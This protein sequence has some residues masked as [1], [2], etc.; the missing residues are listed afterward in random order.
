M[1]KKSG[2][3]RE[4]N[5]RVKIAFL[6]THFPSLSETFILNQVTGLLDRG[7]E[8]HVYAQRPGEMSVTHPDVTRY[9]L[10]ERTR[11]APER[12]GN[13]LHR[14]VR[15]L[16]L[17]LEIG[18]RAPGILLRSLNVLRQGRQAT[19]LKLLFSA[20]PFLRQATRYDILHCHFGP[21]GNL[22]VRLRDIGAASGKIVTTFHG[23]DIRRALGKGETVYAPLRRGGD[24]LLSISQ[25]NR[26]HLQAFGFDPLKIKHHPVG[27][28]L[29][30][31][32]FR[33]AAEAGLLRP[34]GPV[35]ILT[36]ARLVE[37]KGL[38]Y[39]LRAVSAL[40]KARPGLEVDYRIAGDGPRRGALNHLTQELGLCKSVTFLGA[41]D[42]AQVAQLMRESHLFL[43]P[44]VAEALPVVL[45]EAQAVG[46]PVVCTDVG[47]VGELVAD[48]RSG[49]V[50]PPRD[51][52]AL[53]A[54]LAHLV[55][56]PESWPQMG[57][58]GR[59]HVEAH[60]DI[61]QLND[62]LVEI[63]RGLLQR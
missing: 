31:F 28:A 26:R 49:F 22:A 4:E 29:D 3:K 8:V 41:Q 10:L 38:Q 27:I 9:R 51:P 58:A 16:P 45:M 62:R 7:H 42:Q 6:V 34:D 57:R 55:G 63:Y 20:A 52:E 37:E 2:D 33:D 12:P 18:A 17:I 53:A 48:G 54:R 61:E 25:Y 43:L 60:Y 19:S 39:G 36:V 32:V 35:R 44:S 59:T 11:Y 21:N 56:H 13:T 15:A 30:R 1:A 50:V 46:L 5:H 14:A 24:C 47:S 40:L 23:E